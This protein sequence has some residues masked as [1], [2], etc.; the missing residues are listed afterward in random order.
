VFYLFWGFSTRNTQKLREN[1]EILVFALFR[2][3]FA[4]FAFKKLLRERLLSVFRRLSATAENVWN[5]SADF[6]QPL[7]TSGTFPQTFSSR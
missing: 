6:Q 2:G 7:K 1:R 4:S 3:T 5:A